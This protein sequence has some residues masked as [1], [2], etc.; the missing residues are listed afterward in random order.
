MNMIRITI[1]KTQLPSFLTLI[2]LNILL[3]LKHFFYVI[4]RFDLPCVF[5]FDFLIP[6]T[7]ETTNN[8][9]LFQFISALFKFL[10]W[11]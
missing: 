8:S 7:T 1:P 11:C 5:F 3:L 10:Q 6:L 2:Y 9:C 4:N